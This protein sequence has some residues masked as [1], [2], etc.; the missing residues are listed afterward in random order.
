MGQPQVQH[1]SSADFGLGDGE[2]DELV[3]EHCH[4]V[5]GEARGILE[6]VECDTLEVIDC[7]ALGVLKGQVEFDEDLVEEVEE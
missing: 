3:G 7:P 2:G 1:H 6:V 4:Q 5:Q